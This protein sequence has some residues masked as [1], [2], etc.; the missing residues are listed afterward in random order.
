MKAKMLCLLLMA[1]PVILSTQ[2]TVAQM[3]SEAEYEELSGSL[4]EAQKAVEAARAA[5]RNAKN[6]RLLACD[7]LVELEARI[8]SL[9]SG[10]DSVRCFAPDGGFDYAIS[11]LR[12]RLNIIRSE[13]A[14]LRNVQNS[15]HSVIS[16]D[17]C[18]SNIQKQITIN[19]ELENNISTL[20]ENCAENQRQKQGNSARNLF[21]GRD[22]R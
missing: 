16:R 1:T 8:A 21:N 5:D 4:S 6:E 18:I 20:I 15:G 2:L 12:N 22:D 14:Q 9:K 11:N 19:N 10:L 13:T 7:S 3:I 17:G